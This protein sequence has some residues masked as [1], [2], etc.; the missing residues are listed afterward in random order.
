MIR[1]LRDAP[2][3]LA[4]QR[5]QVNVSPPPLFTRRHRLAVAG[6]ATINDRGR[7]GCGQTMRRRRCLAVAAYGDDRQP[8]PYAAAAKRC[9][10]YAGPLH[11]TLDKPAQRGL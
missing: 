5:R 2:C 4:A 7:A 3:T 8:R 6:T 9:A 10:G 1:S 11:K